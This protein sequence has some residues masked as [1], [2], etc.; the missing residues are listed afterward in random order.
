M[1]LKKQQNFMQLSNK[2]HSGSV[3]NNAGTG[4]SSGRGDTSN[5]NNLIAHN[6]SISGICSQTFNHGS[7]KQLKESFN[8]NPSNVSSL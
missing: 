6:V 8:N 5:S 7:G 4:D 3:N 1:R 2:G